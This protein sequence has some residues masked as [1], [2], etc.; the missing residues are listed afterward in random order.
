M[1]ADITSKIV[2]LKA[3]VASAQ[4]LRAEAEGGLNVA[5]QRLAEV[6]GKLKALGLNPEEADVELAALETQLE[7][8]VTEFSAALNAEI[9][10]YNEVVTASKAAFAV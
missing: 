4:K 3:Q 6:D 5:K 8:A 9:A 7:K 2:A 1:A 10:A